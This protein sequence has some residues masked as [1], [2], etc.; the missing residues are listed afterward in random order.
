M[1]KKLFFYKDLDA[2]YIIHLFGIRFCI[3]HRCNF[4]YKPADTYGLNTETERTPRLIVSL[5]SYPARIQTVHYTI[6]TLLRQSLKPDKLILW[7]AKEQFPR[8]EADL[9][10][11]LLRLKNLGL[12]IEW[13]EDLGPY[14]KLIPALE[15]Y[16]DDIIVTADDD[17]YY[18]E[19]MLSSLYT[20]YKQ[21]PSNIYVRRT[22]KI[23]LQKDCLCPVSTRKYLYKHETEPTYFNQLMGGSGCLYPPHSLYKDISDIEQI[24]KLL[25]YHDDVYYWAMAVLNRTKIQVVGGFD[26]NLFFVEG[27]QHVGLIK[28]NKKFGTGTSLQ[29]AYKIMTEKYP[30]IF[31][32]IRGN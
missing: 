25:K 24:K 20:A 21:N 7:L 16:L 28:V 18:E 14:K 29:D 8:G 3:K 31:E 15:K 30:E 4:H 9:P 22:V 17:V 32:I 11:E 26:K 6:N 13:C 1:E 19:D 27:T 12:D 23:E 10:E 5:T 2:H